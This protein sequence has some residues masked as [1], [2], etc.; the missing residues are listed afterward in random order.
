MPWGKRI[1]GATLAVVSV[2]VL[3]LCL[4]GIGGAWMFRSRAIPAVAEAGTSAT[5]ALAAADKTVDQFREKIAKVRNA[6]AAIEREAQRLA[7]E[8]PNEIAA[9]TLAQGNELVVE[10]LKPAMSLANSLDLVAGALDKVLAR[11]QPTH[12]DRAGTGRLRTA[13]RG[14]AEAA[15]RLEQA[16]RGLAEL[17]PAAADRFAKEVR[18]IAERLENV[19]NSLQSFDADLAEAQTDITAVTDAAPRWITLAAWATTLVLSWFALS[20][21]GLLLHA[22]SLIRSGPAAGVRTPPPLARV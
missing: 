14:L 22:W 1:L 18:G 21:V 2:V 9:A 13:I 12:A 7:I 4:G 6:V 3:L 20:Q 15:A 19:E 16:R 5:E 8:P 17:T 11:W 10:Y